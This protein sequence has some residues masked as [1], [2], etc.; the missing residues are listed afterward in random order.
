MKSKAATLERH[1][2]NLMHNFPRVPTGFCKYHLNESKG[3]I[4]GN[5]TSIPTADMHDFIG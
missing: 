2:Q 4:T 1:L 5:L 3:S